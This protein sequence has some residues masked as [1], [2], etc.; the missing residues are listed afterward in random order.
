MV[1]ITIR[2]MHQIFWICYFVK[3]KPFFPRRFLPIPDD[4]AVATRMQLQ[5]DMQPKPSLCPMYS[6]K[7]ATQIE[8]YSVNGYARQIKLLSTEMKINSTAFL[9]VRTTRPPIQSCNHFTAYFWPNFRIL[10]AFFQSFVWW[11]DTI[12]SY[13]LCSFSFAT[14]H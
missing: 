6:G 8:M 10:P 11:P 2:K 1:R 9:C 4:L 3:S 13:F 5:L 7:E 14:K 12:L